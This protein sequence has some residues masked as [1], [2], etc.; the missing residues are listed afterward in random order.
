MLTEDPDP[1]AWISRLTVR[2]ATPDAAEKQAVWQRVVV[3]RAVP[4]GSVH[5][6][7]AAFWSAGQEELLRPFA[8][9]YL[10][11]VP[12]IAD[13]GMMQAMT[14]SK[15]LFPLFGVDEAVVEKVKALVAGAEPVVRAGV[16]ERADLVTRMLRARRA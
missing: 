9:A 12:G 8:A 15:L 13:G 4:L 14:Y 3:D 16:L 7:M 2:A 6:V 10:E 5:Q 1:E 11:L